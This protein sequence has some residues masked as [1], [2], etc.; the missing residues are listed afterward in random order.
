MRPRILS[1]LLTCFGVSTLIAAELEPRVLTTGDL[2]D[3]S[4]WSSFFSAKGDLWF[5]FEDARRNIFIRTPAG[6]TRP[7]FP[8]AGDRAPSG[9]VM[10][11]KGESVAL[12]YRDKIPDKNLYVIDSADWKKFISVGGDTQPLAR[13]KLHGADD[14]IKV[15]WFGEKPIKD[16]P[17]P[18][19]LYYREVKAN[20]DSSG[21]IHRVLPGIY[22]NWVVDPSGAVGVMSWVADG[23]GKYSI[24]SR[25]KAAG[26]EE[27]GPEVVVAEVPQIT[28]LISTFRSGKRWFIY[29]DAKYGDDGL[30]YLLEGAWSDD[31]GST[32]QRFSFPE[33]QGLDITG[34]SAAGDGSNVA[35]A[36]SGTMRKK[37]EG[38]PE[39]ILFLRSADNGTSWEPAEKLQTR[40][41]DVINA[42]NPKLAFG[43]PGEVVVAWQ[44]YRDIRASIRMSYSKNGGKDWTAKDKRVPLT[45][46][47]FFKLNA[48]QEST[49][50]QLGADTIKLVVNQFRDET[51]Q[52]K[53]VVLVELSKADLATADTE[54]AQGESYA[55]EALLQRINSF[56]QAMKDKDYK[57]AYEY[58]DPFFRAQTPYE[59]FWG[60]MGKVKYSEFEVLDVDIK[61][62]V[63]FTKVR[64]KASVPRYKT[65][66]GGEFQ[67]DERE[68]VLDWRWV[69]VD[70]LWQR[71]FRSE[72]TG[73]RS[74]PY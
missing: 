10:A 60:M 20:P 40:E 24:K 42:T 39:Y 47:K 9:L 66:K 21:L 65:A 62:N 59:A 25:T 11:P 17:D 4:T 31:L 49:G 67:A 19:W 43:A 44:D 34:V 15:L 5:A 23:K 73:W 63:A 46:S 30:D 12:A 29:W 55:K 58:Y 14:S 8:E 70:G 7:L 1:L 41:L 64:F 53:D 32:W 45:P 71:E 22:P 51:A 16:S 33:F 50:I 13:V 68:A 36:L 74:T 2:N 3:Q 27:F 72:V 52:D 18:F 6:E 48:D 38:A 69:F 57:A 26:T 54:L 35:I 37:I 28:Y 61:G 56:W